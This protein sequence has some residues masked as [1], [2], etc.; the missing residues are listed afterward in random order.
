MVFIS[1][2]KKNKDKVY[3]VIN[4]ATKTLAFPRVKKKKRKKLLSLLI[5][6]NGMDGSSRWKR[7]WSVMELG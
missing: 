5:K 6:I 4:T 3:A 1:T 2:H 7:L